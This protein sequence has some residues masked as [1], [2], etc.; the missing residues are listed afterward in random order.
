MKLPHAKRIEA[1]RR[2]AAAFGKR[3]HA[4]MNTSG[5]IGSSNFYG[6]DSMPKLTRTEVLALIDCA[7]F[8]W[9][10]DDA[11]DENEWMDGIVTDIINDIK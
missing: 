11:E 7:I 4:A 1:K 5:E 2:I 10:R 3:R 6:D 8:N 9:S